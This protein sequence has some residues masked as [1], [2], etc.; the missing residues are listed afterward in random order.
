[1]E[2][3][4]N[5]DIPS[6]VDVK[7]KTVNAV[8]NSLEIL[9]ELGRAGK[10]VGV[11]AIG[12]KMGLAVSTVHRLLAS[13]VEQE[14]VV[15]V[16]ET[17][18]YTLGRGLLELLSDMIRQFDVRRSLRPIMERLNVRTQETVHLTV[19][20]HAQIMDIDVIDSPQSIGV[21][22]DIGLLLPIHATSV[23][24]IFLAYSAPFQ[25]SL[26]SGEIALSRLTPNTTTDR[27]QLCAE[28]E[29][30]RKQGYALNLAGRTEQTAGSAVPIFGFNGELVAA[31]G[32]S[33]PITRYPSLSH[34]EQLAQLIIEEVRSY[35]VPSAL[36]DSS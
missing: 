18:E 6:I 32:V 25:M 33:G 13:L 35:S 20:V 30:I 1:M 7:P 22:H 4:M 23:G 28:L 12:S 36:K 5:D 17:S 8:V 27:D 3:K 9:R 34:L 14:F 11:H 26:M 24:K 10:P 31:L 21:R 2:E 15:Q 19:A 16:P 29:Q